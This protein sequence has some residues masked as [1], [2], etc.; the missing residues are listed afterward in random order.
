MFISGLSQKCC[1]SQPEICCGAQRCASCWATN[2]QSSGLRASLHGCGR[3]V[4]CCALHSASTG[5]HR[6]RPPWR[7]ISRLTVD[8]DRP[9]RFEIS[10]SDTSS[11]KPIAM[12]LRSSNDSARLE[13]FF[14]RGKHPPFD[15]ST[16]RTD[17]APTD[18][19]RLISVTDSPAFHR[20]HNFSLTVAVRPGRP[21]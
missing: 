19:A 4:N 8:A 6:L 11:S 18:I 2:A 20:A 15:E 12:N 21:S 3:S 7:L 14:G 16:R 10:R 13:R 5:R 17:F 1:F 9:I